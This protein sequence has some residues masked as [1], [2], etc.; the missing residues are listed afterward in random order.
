[1]DKC[2]FKETHMFLTCDNEGKVKKGFE[3]E[4]H[5]ESLLN[6]TGLIDGKP[7]E[8]VIIVDV[9][10][11]NEVRTKNVFDPKWKII[12]VDKKYS[13]RYIFDDPDN[14]KR[15]TTFES[16]IKYALSVENNPYL[17][18]MGG[19]KLLSDAVS[20]ED[21]DKLTVFTPNSNFIS[22][23]KTEITKDL[24]G[25]LTSSRLKNKPVFKSLVYFSLIFIFTVPY[26]VPLFYKK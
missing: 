3:W 16:A 26:L 17:L 25:L 21:I 20:S 8:C 7:E 9:N 5:D 22:M 1:M 2:K 11:Y 24:M 4:K 13:Y 18:I 12:I 14:I 6:V 15:V 23:I 10:V 19:S